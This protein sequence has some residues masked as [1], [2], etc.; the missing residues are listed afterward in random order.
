MGGGDPATKSQGTVV[1]GQGTVGEG[2]L[3]IV[4]SV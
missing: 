2:G 4:G 1:E 3:R